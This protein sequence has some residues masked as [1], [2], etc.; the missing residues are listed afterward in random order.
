VLTESAFV[1][2]TRP[3]HAR[4]DVRGGFDL[5]ATSTRLGWRLTLPSPTPHVFTIATP[6][7]EYYF[8]APSAAEAQ[9]WQDTL[10][11]AAAG[12]VQD[13]EQPQGVAGQGGRLPP[14]G[15]GTLQWP[16]CVLC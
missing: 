1:Y 8:A 4:A 15:E 3:G 9:Q 10:C 16:S 6:H 14:I 7:R 13:L 11:L 2:Y 5:E 12:E